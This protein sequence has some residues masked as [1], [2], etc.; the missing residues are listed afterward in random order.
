MLRM[1]T[2]LSLVLTVSSIAALPA[3]GAEKEKDG[4]KPV[5]AVFAFDGPILEKP[6]GEEFPLFAATRRPTLKDLV[7]RMKKAKNDKNVKA[8]VLLLDQIDPALAKSEELRQALREIKSAGKQVYAHV[9]DALT[10]RS[11]ALAA[12]ASQISATPTAIILISGFNAE[13]PYVRGL[14]DDIG[15]QPDFLHC[16]EYKSAAEIFMRKGPSPAAARMQNWLLDSLYE[17][18]QKA[19]AEGRGVKPERVRQWIDGALY[20]SEQAV[21][22]KIIDRAEYRED[23]ESEL[24]TKFG[25]DVKFDRKYGRKKGRR[26]SIYPR[27]WRCSSS[28]RSS[29]RAGRKSRRART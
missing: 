11:L 6:Q 22:Q 20:T 17:S 15:V 12:G 7:E 21:E 19:V 9:D 14:L 27:P 24:R 16:G 25:E 28:G 3:R 10:T 13:S 29:W 2:A 5:V 4:A 1:L 23:L 18:Y 8:V 26:I